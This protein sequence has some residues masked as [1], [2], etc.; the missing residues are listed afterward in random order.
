[1]SVRSSSATA[2]EAMSSA[3][4]P[5]IAEVPISDPFSKPNFET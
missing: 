4:R 2:L 5:G 3:F 1:V